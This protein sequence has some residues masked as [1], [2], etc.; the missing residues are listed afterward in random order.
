MGGHPLQSLVWGNSRLKSDNT[1]YLALEHHDSDGIITGLAR[2]E[3]RKLPLI[4]KV[5]WVPKGP[6][7]ASVGQGNIETSL[8]QA[9]RER[10]FLACITDRYLLNNQPTPSSPQ[11]IWLDLTLGLDI[12]EKKLDSQWRYGARRALREGVV[13]RTTTE[14]TDVSA[15]FRLC[16]TLSQDKGF[17]LP[18]SEPLMQELI[19]SSPAEGGVGM[20]LYVAEIDGVLAG[21]AFIARSGCHLHYFWG[22]SD[23]RYSKYRVSEALQWQVIQ[24]GVATGMTRYDLEGID[25]V[26]NPGVCQ[27]KRKMGGEEVALEGHRVTPLSLTGRLA[28]AVGRRLGKLA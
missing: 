12:L 23:R 5:A 20:T 21:G 26:G 22:A 8:L 17:S 18:G 11:T 3:I 15:F 2:I 6:V 10:G 14:Q 4:G 9:L 28:V 16:D 7:I 1:G 19:R 13:V 27:F 25:P 24:D